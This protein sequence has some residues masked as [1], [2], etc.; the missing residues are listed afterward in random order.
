MTR[1]CHHNTC[2]VGVATQ[3]PKLRARFTGTPEMVANYLIFVAQEV[4]EILASLGARSLNE[5]IGRTELLAIRPRAD[6]SEKA[7]TTNLALLLDQIDAGPRFHQIERNDWEHDQ[8]LDDEILKQVAKAIEQSTKARLAL[9]IRNI[10]R[11]VGARVAGTIAS[12]YGDK[13]LPAG[14][15][16]LAFTG[17]AGQSFGAFCINGLRL[18][19]IGEANDYVGKAMA[20]GELI[21]RPPD[22]AA[23]AWH[24]NVIMGNTCLYGATGGYLYAAGRAGERFAVR[25]SG[26]VAI[27]EG[28]GDHGCEYMTGGIVVVLGETGRNFGAGMTGGRAYALDRA[29]VFAKRVNLELV[30]LTPLESAEDV[31]IV[32]TL[33]ERHFV[34]TQSNLALDILTN[35]EEYQPLFWM[36]VPKGT[37]AKLEQAVVAKEG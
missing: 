18:I 36:V 31:E 12:R 1:Q 4:R 7:K 23:F 8:P 28:L 16:E 25:N 17:T 27:I 32:R 20:G 10:H 2:P 9:P 14:T 34:A 30:D 29:R 3:D 33:I 15:I 5:L 19:L 26:A 35:W 24:K 11:T 13:G 37:G 22:D 6:L 21:I